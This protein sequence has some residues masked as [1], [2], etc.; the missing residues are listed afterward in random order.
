[1]PNRQ[2]WAALILGAAIGAA[3]LPVVAYAASTVFVARVTDTGDTGPGTLRAA[4]DTVNGLKPTPFPTM[5]PRIE[6][7]IFGSGTK[8]I[9]P[10]TDL[11][12]I[13]VPVVVDGYT[14]TGAALATSTTPAALTVV[15]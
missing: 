15:I 7:R 13:T 10:L 9:T 3:G 14:Q 4:I 2:R 6:F 8:T 1:M 11:P 12:A 5:R